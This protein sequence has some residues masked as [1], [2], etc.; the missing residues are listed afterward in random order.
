MPEN[1][2]AGNVIHVKKCTKNDGVTHEVSIKA[3][4]FGIF[5]IELET[6]LI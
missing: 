4:Y 1:K 6:Q 3:R 5:L 2:E